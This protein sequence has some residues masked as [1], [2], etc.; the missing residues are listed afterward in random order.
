MKSILHQQAQGWERVKAARRRAAAHA[1]AEVP[2][3][4]VRGTARPLLAPAS[5]TPWNRNAA[6]RSGLRPARFPYPCSSERQTPET[7]P[8]APYGISAS[9][10]ADGTPDRPEAAIQVYDSADSD[11]CEEDCHYCNGPETD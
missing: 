4:P 2:S 10:Y 5:T 9:H 6:S 1:P 3:V 11:G 8:A 7:S